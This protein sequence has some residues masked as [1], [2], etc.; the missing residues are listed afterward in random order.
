MCVRGGK[1]S[2]EM[3]IFKIGGCSYLDRLW[4][5]IES[6]HFDLRNCM[7]GLW[8][9]LSVEYVWLQSFYFSIVCFVFLV[10]W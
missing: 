6:T 4:I 2:N 10:F 1:I 3:K 7:F 5:N 9:G 8:G